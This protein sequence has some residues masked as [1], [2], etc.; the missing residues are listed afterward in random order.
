MSTP[1][2]PIKGKDHQ[3]QLLLNGV[4]QDIRETV[5]FKAT[6]QYDETATKPLG[7]TR[8]LNDAIPIGW[9]LEV[10]VEVSRTAADDLIDAIHAA[11]RNNAV[12]DITVVDSYS[13]NDGSRRT[14]TYRDCTLA[15]APKDVSRANNT[16]I[17]FTLKTGQERIQS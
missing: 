7:T 17:S 2:Q 9:Q 11:R 6:P 15:G 1:D 12:A 8:V 10:E 5:S 3:V 14:Y 13:T 16:R 4:N